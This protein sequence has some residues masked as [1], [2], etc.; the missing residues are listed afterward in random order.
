MY[1]GRT[2]DDRV[3]RVDAGG[4]RFGVGETKRGEDWYG[5]D[6]RFAGVLR[7]DESLLTSKPY[8]ILEARRRRGAGATSSIGESVDEAFARPFSFSACL[9]DGPA[10]ADNG[11]FF[12]GTGR[13]ALVDWPGRSSDCPRRTNGDEEVD[14]GRETGSEGG[15]R[16]KLI[17][18]RGEEVVGVVR[19]DRRACN[20][21]VSDDSNL[22]RIR[23]TLYGMGPRE[24]ARLAAGD[25]IPTCSS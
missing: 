12:V 10:P 24:G 15:E 14:D 17:R 13:L 16:G 7:G 3:C 25:P 20:K 19:D 11:L 9:D 5:F 4:L 22:K 21:I 23:L 18:R 1:A 8:S 6:D 2:D